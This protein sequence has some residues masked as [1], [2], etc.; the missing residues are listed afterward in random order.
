LFFLSLLLLMVGSVNLF[1]FFLYCIGI[2]VK[3]LRA[4]LRILSL[5]MMPTFPNSYPLNPCVLSGIIKV[6]NIQNR[7][8][9]ISTVSNRLQKSER[10]KRTEFFERIEFLDRTEFFNRIQFLNRIQLLNR[11]QFLECI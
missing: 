1:L 4:A 9:K 5:K 7:S 8:S 6:A 11:T 3:V 10:L 2:S